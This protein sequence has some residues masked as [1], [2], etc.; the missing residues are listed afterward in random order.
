[1]EDEGEREREEAERVDWKERKR[2]M[3]VGGS[4]KSQRSGGQGRLE[5]RRKRNEP[6]SLFSLS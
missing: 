3:A 1:M 5:K 4:R 2:E 6:E